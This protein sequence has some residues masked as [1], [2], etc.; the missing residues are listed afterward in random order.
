MQTNFNT[1]IQPYFGQ[2]KKAEENNQKTDALILK[3][4]I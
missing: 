3:K 1:D 4:K 2:A